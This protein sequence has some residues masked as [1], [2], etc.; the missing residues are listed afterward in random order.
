MNRRSIAVIIA[1]FFT[2]FIAYSIRYGYG[3]LL[4]EMLTS[5]SISKTQAGVIYSSYFVAYTLFS[6]ILGYMADRYNVRII[7][8][9]FVTLLGIGAFLMSFAS[10]VLNASLFFTLAGIGHAACWVPVV[11]LIQ[12]WVSD[13]KRGMALS[14]ADLGSAT[15]IAVW[16][17]VIPMIVLAYG[18]RVGWRSLGCIGLIV[19]VLNFILVRSHNG[20]TTGNRKSG[21]ESLNKEPVSVVYPMLFK[22]YRFWFIGISYLLVGF[23]VLIP[24]TFL[25]TYAL[26]DLKISYENATRLL[27]VI[28]IMGIA[29]KLTFGTLSDKIGRIRMMVLG[30]VF[31]AAG[32]LGMAFSTRPSIVLFTAVFGVGYGS[33][34]PLYAAAAQDY[35][36]KKY[37]GSVIG[38]WTV[39]LGI[40]SIIAP[41]LGGWSID[42]TG[43]FEAAFILGFICAVIS[44]L[45]LLMVPRSVQAG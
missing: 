6:P 11:A 10:S 14:I 39:C 32:S 24:Y 27:A 30:S 19:A 21:E 28:A 31:L 18:W 20:E 13:N 34:W 44:V 1:G 12:R 23:S 25:S 45:L 7:L 9:I 26:T 43:S 37:A 35:F 33:V 17:N 42:K 15:G 38:L 22:D 3:M 40:G 41:V 36:T 2:I 5:L 4:P 16:S 29:G 8:T